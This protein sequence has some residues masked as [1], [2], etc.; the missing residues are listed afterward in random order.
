MSDEDWDDENFQDVIVEFP[1]KEF[2]E[3][4]LTTRE[5]DHAEAISRATENL[6]GEEE[7]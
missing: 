4:E 5:Y 6:C 2:V 3:V 1:Q 7:A